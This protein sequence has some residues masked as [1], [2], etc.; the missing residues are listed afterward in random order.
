MPFD[1]SSFPQVSVPTV[2]PF[3]FETATPDERLLE[4]ARMLENEQEWRNMRME[5]D[6]TPGMVATAIRE[7]V[8]ERSSS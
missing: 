7:F 6:F 5:W 2:A 1:G 8:A 3:C 4:L